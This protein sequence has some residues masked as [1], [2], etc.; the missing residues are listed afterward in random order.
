MMTELWAVHVEGPILA[1]P[2]REAAEAV[3]TALNRDYEV[4]KARPT[5]SPHDAG[6]HAVVIEWPYD[7]DGH[8][9][10]LAQQAEEASE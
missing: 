2:S 4:F 8:A 6:W 3:A 9:E 1:T 10:S 5:A 7:P